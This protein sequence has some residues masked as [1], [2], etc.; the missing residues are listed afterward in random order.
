MG[1]RSLVVVGVL[2]LTLTATGCG[3]REDPSATP[4]RSAGPSTSP[5]ATAASPAG[6]ASNPSPSTPLAATLIDFAMVPAA[7][8]GSA[9]EI[10][11]PGQI[12]RLVGGP[13]AAVESARAAVARHSGADTRLFAFILAGC[14]NDGAALKI[15]TGRITA[16]LTGGEGIACFVAEWYLALFAVPARL[17]PPGVRIG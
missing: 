10:S 15:E 11:G 2:A 16:T 12:E 6:S 1:R 13:P 17:V 9:T 3:G 8:G 5:T 7:S 4:E 14:Q